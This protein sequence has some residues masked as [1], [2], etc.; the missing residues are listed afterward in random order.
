MVDEATSRDLRNAF[1]E[2]L[3]QTRHQIERLDQV[4]DRLNID[5]ERRE[6]KGI[7]GVVAEGDR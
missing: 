5:R 4:F 3:N 1:Q 2:H 6:C 7:K